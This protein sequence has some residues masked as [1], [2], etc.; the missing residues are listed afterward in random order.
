[1]LFLGGEKM[2]KTLKDYTKITIE[3]ESENPVIIAEIKADAVNI[4]K[5]YR[6]RLTPKYD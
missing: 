4:A 6:V 1:M 2:D 5:G 3:T